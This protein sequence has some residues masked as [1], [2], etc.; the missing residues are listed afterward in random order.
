MYLPSVRLLPSLA[1]LLTC[2]LTQALADPPL[3]THAPAM[4]VPSIQ[5]IAWWAV[6]SNNSHYLGYY[7]GGG[8]TPLLRA[9]PRRPDEGTWGWDYQG[10]LIPRRVNIG[11]WHGRRYQ[12][13]TGAYKTDGPHYHEEEH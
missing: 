6:P 2:A 3:S 4:S 11:W 13:G 7:V 12:G 1:V 10:W 8:C 5:P 9:Q